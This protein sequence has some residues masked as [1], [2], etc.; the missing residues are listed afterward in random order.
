MPLLIQSRKDAESQNISPVLN[1]VIE[2]YCSKQMHLE[3]L[4]VYQ[5]ANGYGV[6]LSVDACKALLGLLGEKDELKLAWCYYASV[7][8][9]GISGDQFKWPVI[10]RILHKDGKF[11][12]ICT[13]FDVGLFTPEMFDLVIDGYS[14]GRDFEAAFDYLNKMCSREIKP[15]FSAYGS[16]LD[17]ACRHQDR[18]VLDTVLSL[19]VERRH[20]AEPH[21]CDYDLIIKKLCDE[22]KT[23]AMDLFFKRAC[24]EKIELQQAT[25]EG[26]LM[27][28]LAEEGRVEDAI[29]LYNIMQEKNILLN[30]KS[31]NEFVIVLCKENPSQKV[32]KLLVDII[33]RGFI[34]MAKELSEYIGKQCAQGRWREAERLLSIV[35]D[36]GCLLDSHCCGSFVKRYCSSRRIDR[37]ITL[38]IKLEELK[39]TLDTAIYN[40]LL[41]AL[42]RHN[43]V[44]EAIKVFDYMKMC[45]MLDG[46]SFSHMITGLC[47][48][49]ELRKAMKLHDEML[50]LGL[51]PDQ[52]TYKRLISGFR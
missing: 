34:S 52:R 17:G 36:Q 50:D 32:T 35:L 37:A 42:Y 49:K 28:L 30:E 22:G 7:I 20:I 21:A 31:Y 13:V 19:M 41:A 1:S 48:V 47:H 25:Y 11:E 51:K 33:S 27:A 10:A 3:S 46:E 24:E 26:M 5:K 38:H 2:C 9:N 40:V 4:E 6:G 12:R 8:R 16:M 43:R 39:G 18:E 45:K 29:N 15:S 14:K 44:E 23:Y